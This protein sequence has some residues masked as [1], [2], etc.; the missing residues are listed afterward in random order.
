M[1]P[2][3]NARQTA[4]LRAS[5][6]CLRNPGCYV[7]AVYVCLGEIRNPPQP[8]GARQV[9]GAAAGCPRRTAPGLLASTGGCAGQTHLPFAIRFS[10]QVTGHRHLQNP[11]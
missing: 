3:R 8:V 1:Q 7:P 6:A 10:Q 5:L 4:C 2:S 9:C 11:A